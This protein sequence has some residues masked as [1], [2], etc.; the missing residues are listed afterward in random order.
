MADYITLSDFAER[1]GV[2]RQAVRKNKKLAEYIHE[3]EGKPLMIDTA[4]LA[5]YEK[6]G[7]KPDETGAKPN[8][9]RTETEAKPKQN[10]TI[11]ETEIS[12]TIALLREQLAERNATIADLRTQIAAKDAQLLDLT[13]RMTEIAERSGEIA[14]KAVYALQQRQALDVAEIKAAFDQA[15]DAQTDPD[16]PPHRWWEIWR[17]KK[18]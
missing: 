1:V 11:T 18:S 17:R 14:D 8:E 7:A 3:E 10:Q 15:Q 9:N 13:R 4:A 16:E 12:A 6:T 2:S 5:V